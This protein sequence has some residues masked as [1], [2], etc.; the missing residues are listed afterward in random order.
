MLAKCVDWLIPP[1]CLACRLIVDT[2]GGLCSSCWQSIDFIT[3]PQ[4][5]ACGF[6]FEF[7]TCGDG[8]CGTCSQQL[9]VYHKARS[10][11]IYNDT[12]KQ[13]ILRF[14]HADGTHAAPTFA[15]WM[16]R[17]GSELLQKA[18]LLIPVPLHWTRLFLRR[19]NQAA[20][21]VNALSK[22]T[23][24]LCHNRMLLRSRY[25]PS[26]GHLNRK[27]REQNVKQAFIVPKK[28][29]EYLSHKKVVLVDDV[30]TS[31]ATVNACTK[32]LLKHGAKSVNVLLLARVI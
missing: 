21:L 18:D 19:Y 32:A 14:K 5:S 13:L 4:C 30:Y 2:S 28:Y 17:A 16:A 12:S 8:L 25:T 29:Q 22:E 20:L 31:G 6:P 26:Q 1:R 10:A 27:E 11:L 23:R 3:D 15:R 9:P 24:L 7:D